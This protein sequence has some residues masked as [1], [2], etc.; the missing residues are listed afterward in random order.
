[1]SVLVNVMD[2]EPIDEWKINVRKRIEG[3]LSPMAKDARDQLRANIRS[4]PEEENWFRAEYQRTMDDIRRLAKEQF[5]EELERER[6]ERRWAAGMSWETDWVESPREEQETI[7]PQTK[8]SENGPVPDGAIGAADGGP[9]GTSSR[10]QT[11]VADGSG[12]K[13]VKWPAGPSVLVPT[14][15]V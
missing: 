15:G 7:Y 14:M 1:M 6:Q 10:A 11:M 5:Q 4:N 8:Q 9:T 3:D 13:L 12:A 2:L